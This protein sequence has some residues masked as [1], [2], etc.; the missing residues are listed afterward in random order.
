MAS[1]GKKIGDSLKKLLFREVQVTGFQEL[2]ASFKRLELAGDALKTARCAPG[3]KVQL[4]LDAGAR[5]YSPF[6][7]DGA[8]GRMSL[9]VYLHGNTSSVAWAK[10]VPEGE[11]LYL[12][13]PRS[14]LALGSLSGPV[15]LFGDE[16]S[17]GVARALLE[18]RP[19]VSELGFVFETSHA[20]ESRLVLDAL[21]LPSDSLIER[22]P[23]DAQLPAVE[24]RLRAALARNPASHLVFTGK[25][26]SI[27]ALRKALKARPVAHAS[28]TVK[29]YWSPGKRGLD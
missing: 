20:G 10:G 1:I 17:F 19:G 15:V 18:S 12:F 14:S 25:A 3:D 29:A 8:A 4:A 13:G 23:D 6:A 22:T 21:E 27:Q 11:R 16:T 9:L 5:T 2:S 24:E 28:Q 26:Q 7:W